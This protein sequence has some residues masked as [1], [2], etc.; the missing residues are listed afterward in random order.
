MEIKPFQY[1][2]ENRGNYLLVTTTGTQCNDAEVINL[3]R[4]LNDECK[5]SGC[6][7]VLLNERNLL[8]STNL[9]DVLKVADFVAFHRNIPNI[10]KIACVP[11]DY[12]EANATLFQHIATSKH[13]GYCVLDTIDKAVEWLSC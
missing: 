4:S 3:Y 11:G 13:I 1:T 2:V 6:S 5:T 12:S 9:E 10:S 8:V 7:N